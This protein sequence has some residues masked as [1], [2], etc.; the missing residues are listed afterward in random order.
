MSES[1]PFDLDEAQRSAVEHA[2]RAGVSVLTGGPGTGKSRTVAALVALA[3]R[4]GRSV[5]LAAPT[6]R[7]AKR[8]EELCGAPAS[9]LHRLLGAQPRTR[10]EEVSFDGGFA[11]NRDWPLDED[12]V[13]VDEA[14]M[15]DVELANASADRLR[16]RH[17]SALRRRCGPAAVDRSRT[18]ARLTSSTPESLP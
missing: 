13:V 18:S 9:T 17:P 1:D 16:G 5:A 7:A 6:G 15:L 8:L 4:A 3:E 11:R 10:G 2:L 12:V 14:S